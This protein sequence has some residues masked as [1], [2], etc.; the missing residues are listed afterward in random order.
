MSFIDYIKRVFSFAKDELYKNHSCILCER[1][2]PDGE[3]FS[4]CKNCKGNIEKIEPPFCLKCGDHV[5]E[6]GGQC[7]KCQKKK[8]FFDK[9]TSFFYYS[10]TIS[11]VI[12]KMKY[13][14]KKYF[15]KIFAEMMTQNKSC[16]EQIDYITFVP[17]N[18]K[19]QKE[20]GFNQAEEI[21]REISKIVGI[22]VVNVLTKDFSKYNQAE[23]SGKER[24]E[25]LK[26]SFH[27]T[28]NGD[29]IKDKNIL[30]IDDVFTTGT[31]LDRCS[32]ELK[33]AKPKCIHT[34]TLAKTKFRF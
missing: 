18:E 4:L 29:I 25:N 28:R 22:E 2:I 27:L 10:G 26:G 7:L 20:R 1:E 6:I 24:L 17:M 19:K 12:K 11:A 5:D 23:L 13:S 30:I 33:K 9:N 21:A 15:S 16:F 34:M 3:L 8:Y 14:S 32:E 31:T